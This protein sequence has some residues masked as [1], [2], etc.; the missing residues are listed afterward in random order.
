MKKSAIKIA[1]LKGL[2]SNNFLDPTTKKIF[3][4]I[5]DT[6]GTLDESIDGLNDK[7][8]DLND[9]FESIDDALAIMED[10][11]DDDNF[12]FLYDD[13]DDDAEDDSPFFGDDFEEIDD[14]ECEENLH[15]VHTHPAMNLVV[16]GRICTECKRLFL[17]DPIADPQSK[18]TCPF[19]G[20]KMHPDSLS[21]DEIP[22]V[23]P[24]E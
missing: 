17:I 12:D 13:D 9:Y 4:G 11:D 20:A 22:V 2:V 6:L 14:D 16:N 24:E 15:V 21:I 1:Y 7:V 8:V 23:T 19:C 18:F 10:E 5:L 3:E